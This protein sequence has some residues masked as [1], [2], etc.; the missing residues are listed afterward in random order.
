LGA[1]FSCNINR[2]NI[3]AMKGPEM[4]YPGRF[5][6]ATLLAATAFVGICSTAVAQGEDRYSNMSC[7]ELWHERNAIYAHNG[8]CFR[9]ERAIS[10]FGR[11]CFPPYGRLS[12]RERER[13]AR[14][15]RWE[16]RQDC[17]TS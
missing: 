11:G 7:R 3:I 9:T 16:A 6:I 5:F 1:I 17:P 12:P 14:I 10:V 13:V 2:H 8:Y 4:R 15:Q